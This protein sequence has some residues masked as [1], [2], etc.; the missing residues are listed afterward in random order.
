V[1][2]LVSAHRGSCGVAGLALAESYERAISLGVD[3][4]EF[5]LRR[6]R[7][8][9]YVV[10]HD[11]RLENGE[12]IA[13]LTLAG[14]RRASGDQALTV[15]ELLELVGDRTG[16]H[17]DLKEA[18][19]EEGALEL[20]LG[21][22]DPDRLVVT[23]GEDPSIRRLKALRPELRVGLSLGRE[24]AGRP[25]WEVGV[26]RLSELFPAGRVA[27]C[28]ADFLAA[29]LRLARAT[30]LGFCS[31]HGL[32]AWV[33]TVD[34]EA[35]MRRLLAD[36]RLAVLITNRPDLALE[37]R[38]GLPGPAQGPAARNGS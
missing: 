35:E 3:Y 24:M 27:A 8:G 6:T 11:P 32:P 33:W 25:P 18:G 19:D 1:S 9:E 20:L 34:E 26:V 13:D 12:R 22:A 17:A 37:I 21:R 7:D 4:V 14:Y 23:T 5:D 2:A 10:H 31:R 29:E 30:L 16:L 38:G 28:G 36:P 15:E